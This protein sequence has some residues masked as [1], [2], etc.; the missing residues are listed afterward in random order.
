MFRSSL[1]SSALTRHFDQ[2]GPVA[3]DVRRNSMFR[4]GLKGGSNISVRIGIIVVSIFAAASALAQSQSVSGYSVYTERSAWLKA[5]GDAGITPQIGTQTFQGIPPAYYRWGFNDVGGFWYATT[6]YSEVNVA[7]LDN[8]NH[9]LSTTSGPADVSTTGLAV[10]AIAFD[11]STVPYYPYCGTPTDVNIYLHPDSGPI[12]LP[13][14]PVGFVGIIASPEVRSINRL[15]VYSGGLCAGADIV[16]LD[17]ISFPGGPTSSIIN[18]EPAVPC[19]PGVP[20]GAFCFTPPPP[21]IFNFPSPW[22][23]YDPPVTNA[24]DFSCPDGKFVSL[25]DFPPGFEAPF[26]VS[27]GGVVLGSF[28][29]GQSVQFPN[30]GV[31]EFRISGISPDVDGE[32]PYAFP[33][34][35]SL[36]TVGVVFTM[37]PLTLPNDS[38][39]PTLLLP[40]NV[41]AEATGPAGAVV[42]YSTAATDNIDPQPSVSCLPASGSTF[43]LG[44]TVVHCS[45]SDA[46]GNT[47]NGSFD[48]SVVDTTAPAVSVPSDI[49]VDAVSPQ[50]TAVNFT[51]SAADIA[52]P[53]PEVSC[54]RTSGSTFAIGSTIVTCTAIDRSQNATR[55]SFNIT[56]IGASTQTATLIALVQSFNLAPGITNSLN[57]KLR[58]VLAALNAG[59]ADHR[60]NACNQLGAFVNAVTAQAGTQPTVSQAEQLIANA[61]Q[62]RAVLG[63][64]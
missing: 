1:L 7:R 29:P 22:A 43:A 17:N 21:I 42:V 37:R 55:R 33:I 56:V 44:Q 32:N 2:S 13:N 63:C 12:I 28:L 27:T 47:S 62:I 57:A 19:P 60:A 11:V 24:F 26:T 23:W 20:P 16:R 30:G 45:A 36:D 46:A 58:N 61:N 3:I 40:S 50:G 52:D 8:G 31:H 54:S 59:N 5:V 49:V 18:P 4:N 35:L 14:V 10:R 41:T 25:N 53:A 51:V 48:V 34:N 38:I 9:V 6:L 64:Q 39:A 15:W